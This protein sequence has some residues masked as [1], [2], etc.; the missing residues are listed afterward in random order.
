MARVGSVMSLVETSASNKKS[1]HDI[2]SQHDAPMR[3]SQ[4][5]EQ[6]DGYSLVLSASELSKQA[7]G[8]SI[9]VYRFINIPRDSFERVRHER[10]HTNSELQTRDMPTHSNYCG[11]LDAIGG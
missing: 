2:Y 5:P 3:H 4:I 8:T 7:M 1:G 11:C 10:G 6:K 9:P